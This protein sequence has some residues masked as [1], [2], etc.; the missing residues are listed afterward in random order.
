VEILTSIGRSLTNPAIIIA[1]AVIVVIVSIFRFFKRNYIQVP[2]NRVAV[3][4][5]RSKPKY[6]SGGGHLRIPIIE[7]IL[8]M[9]LQP[10]EMPVKLQDTP[11]S[12]MVPVT[13][14]AVGLARIGSNEEQ[15]R[16]A[17]DRF[18]GVPSDMISSQVIEIFTGG[19][20]SIVA[21]MTIEELNK[22]REALSTRVMEKIG[23]D[24]GILGISVDNFTIQ[25]I[26]DSNGYIKALGKAQA[27]SVKRD[28]EIAEAEANMTSRI[29]V[30]ASKQSAAE[31]EAKAEARIAD[32]VKNRDLEI[33]RFKAETDA[34]TAKADQAGP[35]AEA[36]AREAVVV[37]S[38]KV[39]AAQAQAEIEVN[40][41]RAKVARARL[42]A[43]KI[44]PANAEKEAAI[45]RA[46]GEKQ[47]KIL[48]AE[49]EAA[50]VTL[51]GD[52]QA[53]SSKAMLMANAEGNA[54]QLKL[55]GD[56][57]AAVISAKLLAEAEGKER[58]AA[59][60]NSFT[61][62]SAI[63]Y[64][65]P[66]LAQA[67]VDATTAAATQIAG[68]DN[69]SIIGSPETAK[70]GLA[71]LLGAAPMLIAGVAESLKG[72]GIDLS[73]LLQPNDKAP[74]TE[75]SSAVVQAREAADSATAKAKEPKSAAKQA[76]V[77]AQEDTE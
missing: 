59:A 4:I 20:R 16:T 76:P 14:N 17:A 46:D 6:V 60:Y 55:T 50:R 32:A 35:L 10:F 70:G 31:A 64:L 22:N 13:I 67:N 47:A 36:E 48:E 49:A 77:T 29:K 54:S 5:G 7:E 58:L 3:I 75:A 11:D 28:S 34:E 73:T 41:N 8:Y 1:I 12:N 74:S 44:E 45:V 72:S 33:A 27:A 56:A 68:I 61:P 39:D 2:T 52:A 21:D 63:V 69:I 66:I 37:A 9:S 30:A 23:E 38:A 26:D 19:L 57:E 15:I 40:E 65:T 43:E 18:A 25:S 62:E 24:L 53:A 71:S 42:Q 51:D